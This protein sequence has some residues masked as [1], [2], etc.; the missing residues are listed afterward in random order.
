MFPGSKNL[1]LFS[2][3]F[4]ILAC[5]FQVLPFN[6]FSESFLI[7]SSHHCFFLWQLVLL[8]FSLLTHYNIFKY[9]SGSSYIIIT[10]WCVCASLCTT[11]QVIIAQWRVL[12]HATPIYKKLFSKLMG[13]LIVCMFTFTRHEFSTKF[14]FAINKSFSITWQ[15]HY[16]ITLLY[17]RETQSCFV[18]NVFYIEHGL[19]FFF[20]KNH[21]VS[22]ITWTACFD[23]KKRQ[24]LRRKMNWQK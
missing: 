19:G 15:G 20:L 21:M 9:A 23:I 4:C 12:L 10:F 16:K 8:L 22:N 17:L 6:H 1:K 24:L 13:N 11:L 2:K 18:F 3:F 7:L 5:V 14:Y